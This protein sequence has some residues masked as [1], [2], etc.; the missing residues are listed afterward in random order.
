[1]LDPSSSPSASSRFTSF[2]AH[3]RTV[4]FDLITHIIFPLVTVVDP[5]IAANTRF[6]FF[7]G[8]SS[9]FARSGRVL[10]LAGRQDLQQFVRKRSL[11]LQCLFDRRGQLFVAFRLSVRMTGIAFEWTGFTILFGS[12]VRNEK[13]SC[14]PSTGSAFV[15]REPF[16]VRQIPAKKKIGRGSMAPW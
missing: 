8:A 13:I 15:P 14:S 4:D 5:S 2:D 16:H 3:A 1:M 10:F 7:S 9:L 12:Y 11:Q 6:E